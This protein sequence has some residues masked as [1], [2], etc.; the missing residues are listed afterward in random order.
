M[1][2]NNRGGYESNSVNNSLNYGIKLKKHETHNE[3]FRKNIFMKRKDF[4]LMNL[5]VRRGINK[6]IKI[7]FPSSKVKQESSIVS[8]PQ[9]KHINPYKKHHKIEVNT[10]NIFIKTQTY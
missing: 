7:I 3:K 10:N 4:D 2:V 9:K 5:L 8:P 1:S 6:Q